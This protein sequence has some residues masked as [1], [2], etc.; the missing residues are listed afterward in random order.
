[1]GPGCRDPVCVGRSIQP[2]C[3]HAHEQTLAGSESREGSEEAKLLLDR[4]D[5][6]H[7]VRS[8]LGLAALIIFLAQKN[9]A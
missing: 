4:W 9:Y 7:R 5:R 2:Y 6:L 8:A 1:M 3:H